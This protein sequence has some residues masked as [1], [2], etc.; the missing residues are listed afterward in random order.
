MKQIAREHRTYV[1]YA[2]LATS[3]SDAYPHRSPIANYISVI[4]RRPEMTM[5]FEAFIAAS[6]VHVKLCKKMG[7][8]STMH[9]GPQWKRSADSQNDYVSLIADINSIQEC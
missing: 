5:F 8:T 3:G 2:S 4:T 9:R 7:I 1:V 6:L